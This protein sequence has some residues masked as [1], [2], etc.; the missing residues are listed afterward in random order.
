M[1]YSAPAKLLSKYSM[2]AFTCRHGTAQHWILDTLSFNSCTI[3]PTLSY[4]RL[5]PELR[6]AVT[7][8]PGNFHF[9]TAIAD[10]RTT[11]GQDLSTYQD[12]TDVFFADPT[13][14]L[15][16]QFPLRVD[17]TFPSLVDSPYRYMWPSHLVLF[18]ALLREPGV[19][20]VLRAE[21]YEEVWR[22]DNGIEEDRRRRG[23]VRVWR[24]DGLDATQ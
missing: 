20:D 8:S 13:A 11:S 23:G 4:P 19:K 7:V 18:G 3:S 6:A 14:F 17:P 12:E 21:G 1:I 24:W 9:R 10:L 15:S 5:A 16:T 22:G 2:I